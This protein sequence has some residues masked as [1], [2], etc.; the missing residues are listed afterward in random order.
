MEIQSF[1]DESQKQSEVKTAIVSKYF[2]AWAKVIIPTA[3]K[4]GNRIA[5]IDLFA[6]P[7]RYEDG[8]K[9]TPLL[10]LEKAIEDD[11]MQNMLVSIFNDKDEDHCRSLEEALASLPGI[12]NLRYKL[13]CTPQTGHD[14]AGS[15]KCL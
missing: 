8:T 5:Y 15:V 4:Y 11:D 1:F 6:G 3:K 12:E 10:V 2:W 9:S 7:G 14:G 13:E